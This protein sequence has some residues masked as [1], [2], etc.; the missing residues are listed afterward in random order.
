M[1]P[2]SKNTKT[3]I[4]F[5]YYTN[6]FCTKGI[7][8]NTFDEDMLKDG[9]KVDNEVQPGLY[10]IKAQGSQSADQQTVQFSVRYKTRGTY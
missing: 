7:K 6:H 4:L 8:G 9:E 3:I 2:Y 5:H 1:A 10:L